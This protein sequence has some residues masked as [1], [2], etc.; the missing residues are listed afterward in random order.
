MA[1]E[2]QGLTKEEVDEKVEEFDRLVHTALQQ[3]VTMLP[4]ASLKPHQLESVIRY[5]FR[6]GH[7]TSEILS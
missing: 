2:G 1:L 7:R 4:Y 5:A 3:D 6:E